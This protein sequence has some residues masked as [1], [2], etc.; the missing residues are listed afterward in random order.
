M[1]NRAGKRER[2][3]RNRHKRGTISR[4]IPTPTGTAWLTLKAGH[5]KALGFLRMTLFSK[6][7]RTMAAVPVDDRG[8]PIKT[9]V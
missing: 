9:D 3:A 5:R 7:R 6:P 8:K 1:V 4:S 2:Q